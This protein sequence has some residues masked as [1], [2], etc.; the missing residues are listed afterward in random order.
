MSSLTHLADSTVRDSFSNSYR[1]TFVGV[2]ALMRKMV[3]SCVLIKRLSES[4]II[5]VTKILIRYY[6]SG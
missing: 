6:S 5:P 2:S 3:L 1:M 4:R